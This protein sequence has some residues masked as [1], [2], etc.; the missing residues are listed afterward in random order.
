MN[1]FKNSKEEK[2][3]DQVAVEGD[4]IASPSKPGEQD[5]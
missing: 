4:S 1:F 2:K 3:D 5:A